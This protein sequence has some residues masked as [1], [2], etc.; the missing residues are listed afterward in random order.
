M[1]H[2]LTWVCARAGFDD[3]TLQKFLCETRF[4]FY[5]ATRR[6]RCW[7]YESEG[8]MGSHT[9]LSPKIFKINVH[10]GYMQVPLST[11]FPIKT[12]LL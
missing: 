3:S 12:C 6:G 10:L 2:L 4:L 1:F 8:I 5:R 11:N 9:R 7:Y